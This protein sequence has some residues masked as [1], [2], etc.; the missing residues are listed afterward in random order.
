[1][2][3]SAN[4]ARLLTLTA[5][6]HDL[7]LRAQQIS[8]QKMA[9]MFQS[10]VQA[11]NYANAL[12]A[13][14]SNGAYQVSTPQVVDIDFNTEWFAQF[15]NRTLYDFTNEVEVSNVRELSNAQIKAYMN[16]GYE[17]ALRYAVSNTSNNTVDTNNSVSNNY[18]ITDQ[19]AF[20]AAL[21]RAF[22]TRQS[23]S[24][25]DNWSF[26]AEGYVQDGNKFYLQIN[27][28]SLVD[29]R[30]VAYDCL[31]TSGLPAKADI[32]QIFEHIRDTKCEGGKEMVD[33]DFYK[34]FLATGNTYF[35]VDELASYGITVPGVQNP[36]TPVQPSAPEAPSS[37]VTYSYTRVMTT[38][39][40]Y[41]PSEESN[42]AAEDME[43]AKTAYDAAMVALSSTEKMLDMELTQIDTEHKAVVTERDSVKSLLKDNTE[44]SFNVFG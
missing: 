36:S 19:D 8:A 22:Q 39:T 6:Q 17:P 2:G 27:P 13:Y 3:I 41:V 18:N 25:I 37:N 26:V 38:T 35:T 29:G 20:I 1:M 31:N 7:E 9:L 10:Q 16:A 33:T 40:V 24:G 12:A 44:K 34:Y 28:Y 5:R 14:T 23:N 30:G 21:T 4:Q 43:A 11:T 32:Q 15:S 42:A